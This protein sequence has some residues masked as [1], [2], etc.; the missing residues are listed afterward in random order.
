MIIAVDIAD[1]PDVYEHCLSLAVSVV[2]EKNWRKVKVAC[3]SLT[4]SALGRTS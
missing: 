3:E 1:D 2:A 4:L